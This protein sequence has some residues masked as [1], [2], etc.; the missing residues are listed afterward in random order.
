VARKRVQ[1]AIG[2][3][4][5][6][7]AS[8]VF[9][10][11]EEKIDGEM[12]A[13]RA[14]QV[15]HRA[16][17]TRLTARQMA[18]WN[19][20]VWFESL[21]FPML[22]PPA[23]FPDLSLFPSVTGSVQFDLPVPRC[24]TLDGFYVYWGAYIQPSVYLPIAIA[25]TGI[26][27]INSNQV[28]STGTTMPNYTVLSNNY[29]LLRFTAA[30]VE[31][32][33]YAAITAKGGQIYVG[34]LPPGQWNT[35]L[36]N[37]GNSQNLSL[38]ASA[39]PEADRLFA[40]WFPL[41]PQPIDVGI[42]APDFR[43]TGLT[44]K[45][46]L[47]S[48]VYDSQAGFF[49]YMPTAS[50]IAYDSFTVRVTFHYEAIPFLTSQMLF[51]PQTV[52]GSSEAVTEVIQLAGPSATPAATLHSE[53][54]PGFLSQLKELGSG[55]YNAAKDIAED[56]FGGDIGDIVDA[57]SQILS[58]VTEYLPD[59]LSF[60]GAPQSLYPKHVLAVELSREHFSPAFVCTNA[61]QRD[62][63]HYC[64]IIDSMSTDAFTGFL[65][66]QE[67]RHQV[68]Q[69]FGPGI[70]IKER[71]S[72][73][74]GIVLDAVA[75]FHSTSPSTPRDVACYGETDETSTVLR[76]TL[77]HSAASKPEGPTL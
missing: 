44:Y 54:S 37:Y 75:S 65:L 9:K 67:T 2:H 55:V 35:S 36:P 45:S 49:A 48:S 42:A 34:T 64:S 6:P 5:T 50:G 56:V 40:S 23:H 76:L 70:D 25:Q 8:S 61:S 41:S 19:A 22:N 13:A 60:F 62:A 27:T 47:S 77:A 39:D 26:A 57:G 66:K 11:Q 68:E 16:Q 53:E 43:P 12:D 71:E 30:A 33:D 31:I 52:V 72:N 18:D 46:P 63:R 21:M 15:P 1:L 73:T 29:Q 38:Y 17:P 3:G 51:D 59:I 32:L 24:T 69:Q 74:V 20:S 28:Y 7:S 14:V 58:S 4:S 10:E